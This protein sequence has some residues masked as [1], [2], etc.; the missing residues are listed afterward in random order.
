[1]EE[2]ITEDI[3]EFFKR[4][5]TSQEATSAMIEKLI[6]D[7]DREGTIVGYTFSSIVS[8][9]GSLSEPVRHACSL[10][11]TKIQGIY[12][13]KLVEEGHS[14]D[15]A[16]SIALMM[17]A[18]IEGGIMLCLTKRTNEP[19]RVISQLLLRLVQ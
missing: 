9:M 4:Y 3:E 12:S 1:M 11:Y 19:L 10:L 16:D 7:F 14:K 5:P 17:T 13:S 15:T 6:A 8:E 18:S 2:A